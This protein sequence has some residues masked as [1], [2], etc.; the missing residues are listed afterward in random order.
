MSEHA[1]LAPSSAHRWVPCP[2]SVALEALYPETVQSEPAREGDAAH[3]ALKEACE[4]R[5]I[6][7]GQI[8]PNDWILDEDMV[9]GAELMRDDIAATG[10]LPVAHI[11]SRLDPAR[12]IHPKNWGT[13]DA[14][15]VA[16]YARKIYL[17]DYKFGHG[18]VE[19]FENWQ[20]ANYLALIVERLQLNGL[21]EQAYTVVMTI[22]QPR[23]YHRDGHVRRWTVPLTDLR[24][25]WNRLHSSAEAAFCDK[26]P[27]QT[28][29]HCDH[30]RA[31]H[32]CPALHKDVTR[33]ATH[34]ETAAPL[35]LPD[36]ALGYEY[37]Q[38]KRLEAILTA[39]L[40]GLEADAESRLRRGA[41]IP[42][43]SLTSAPGREHWT[44]DDA[45]AATMFGAKPPKP[46]TPN[47]ARKA[48]I[49]A[50]MVDPFTKREQTA[51]K[52][53]LVT[54]DQVRRIFT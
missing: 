2:G 42:W 48:G 33:I 23:V 5:M 30:C 52:V 3:W 54:T 4:G 16:A 34:F 27:L 43:L 26:P 31:R 24:G 28:G 44:V 35:E 14:W 38:L 12:R 21:A 18:L 53:T 17:W 6:A 29:E 25:M 37:R 50:A 45:T 41:R 7:E 46:V 39:R 11:E 36:N 20:L 8:A 15:A 51:G 19:V 9:D 22:V 47:Q 32:A 40:T 13:P 49:P 1:P 10:L